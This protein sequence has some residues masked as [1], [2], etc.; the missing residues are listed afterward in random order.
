MDEINSEYVALKGEARRETTS[1]ERLKELASIRDELVEIVAQNVVAPPE[2]LAD[3]ASHKNKA[4]RKAVTSN[5]NTPTKTLLDLG[6]YF[7][8]ELLNNPVFDFLALEDLDFVKKI[9]LSTLASLIQR[10]EVPKF[11]L[12]YAVSFKYHEIADIAKMHVAISGEMTEGW[13]AIAKLVQKEPFASPLIS[14]EE[15]KDM[16]ISLDLLTNFTEFVSSDL[17]ENYR[18]REAIALNPN[19]NSMKLRRL[20]KD[21][22]V[23][24]RNSVASNPNTPLDIL[25]IKSRD[26]NYAVRNSVAR[27]LKTPTEIL[28]LLA[29]DSRSEV[30]QNVARNLK[31][32]TKILELLANDSE[33]KVRDSLS[34]NPNTPKTILESYGNPNNRD[35]LLVGCIAGNPNTPIDVL[36][37]LLTYSDKSRKSLAKNPSTPTEILELLTQNSHSEVRQNVARN[38]ST[39]THILKS[40]ANSS[41]ALIRASVARNCNI[42]LEILELLANDFHALVRASVAQNPRISKDTLKLLIHDSDNRVRSSV[43]KNPNTSLEILQL[44]ANDPDNQV[45]SSVAKN[46]KCTRQIKE[47]IFKKFAKSEIPSFSRVALFLSDYAESSVLAENSNSISWLERYAIAQNKKTPQDTLKILA[48]DGNRIVRATAKESLQKLYD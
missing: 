44:L 38:P 23:R 33:K 16:H 11:L 47:T 29:R 10:K 45:R 9:P 30:R 24:V 40:F 20:A 8:Q 15:K 21:S 4:V 36:K 13:H 31:T 34:V 22:N 6:T 39:P 5:P 42:P 17:F 25:Q 2:L 48:Q 3:L 28:E 7:P 27:N 32:P 19:T 43:T 26:D 18:F 12:N 14:E 35:Y 41:S 1:K 46:P 37:S